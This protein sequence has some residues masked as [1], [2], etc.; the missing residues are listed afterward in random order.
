MGL[1]GFFG[2]V[3]RRALT[4]AAVHDCNLEFNKLM[5]YSAKFAYR[6][7][8]DYEKRIM[9]DYEAKIQACLAAIKKEMTTVLKRE[10]LSMSVS[11]YDGGNI[12]LELYYD[13]MI[14]IMKD[15]RKTH[16]S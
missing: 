9:L 5:A 7:P 6:Q 14:R 12:S 16:F 11:N 13:T 4:H 10:D 8:Q 1:F 15:F 3:Q 2:T